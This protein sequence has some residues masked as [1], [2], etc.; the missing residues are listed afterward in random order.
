MVLFKKAK[1]KEQ[2]KSDKQEKEN[3][4]KVV[5]K[6]NKHSLFSC[7]TFLLNE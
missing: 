5:E 3:M 4:K 7:I 2:E 1:T 6:F